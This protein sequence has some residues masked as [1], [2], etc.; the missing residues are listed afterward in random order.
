MKQLYILIPG[1]ILSR[2]R[3][4]SPSAERMIG[5]EQDEKGRLNLAKRFVLAKSVHK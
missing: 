1:R 4:E 2:T 3:C 5:I